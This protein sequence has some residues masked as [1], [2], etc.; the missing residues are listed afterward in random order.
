MSSTLLPAL[1]CS[2]TTIERDTD[3]EAKA[4]VSGSAS[5]NPRPTVVPSHSKRKAAGTSA[6]GQVVWKAVG[7][8][9]EAPLVVAAAK[10]GLNRDAMISQYQ[11]VD[12]IAFTSARKIMVTIHRL[13]PASSKTEPV[14]FGAISF[15]P[16]THFVVC[17]KGAPNYVLKACSNVLVSPG[18][19]SHAAAAET[20]LLS[21]SRVGD[22]NS[23]VDQFSEQALRCLAVAYRPLSEMPVCVCPCDSLNDCV[24]GALRLCCC[25]VC[26]VRVRV[27]YS[28]VTAEGDSMDPDQKL[29]ATVKG[30]TFAGIVASMDPERDGVKE[31]LA[32]ARKASIRTVMIT[33]DYLKTAI[34]I[35]KNIGL[36]PLGADTSIRA[37][38]CEQLRYVISSSSTA[39]VSA[40]HLTCQSTPV[41]FSVAV[42][43]LCRVASSPYG[44]EYLPPI[45]IDELTMTA[46]VFARAKPQDKLEIVKSL[47]RQGLVCAMTGDGVNDAPALKR[48]DIGIAM[49]LSGTSVAKAAS[50]MIL[51]D[52]NF[53]TIVTAVQQGRAIYANIQKF[54]VFLIGTNWAQILI[55]F[56]SVCL[57]LPI[58]LYPLQ[59][60]FI[61]LA[62]DGIPAVALAVEE[63]EED[64]MDFPPRSKHTPIIAGQRSLM[65]LGHFGSLVIVL[66]INYILSLYW[67]TGHFFLHD[68]I[69]PCTVLDSSSELTTQTDSEC[70]ARG[71][72]M[73]RT[74]VFLT[75]A[76]AENLRCHTC[77]YFR[78][79]FLTS[80]SYVYRL[81]R[82]PTCL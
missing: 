62:T 56:V 67:Y 79:S 69:A 43:V 42:D 74:V 73:A 47:Q 40:A 55:I 63:G 36:L 21:P 38:D 32:T 31:A 2:N 35:G 50:E 48:A 16:G 60:L 68:M 11:R 51:V 29:L 26:A 77:R 9:S 8:T 57:G 78:R 22:I 3:K 80:K 20:V 72:S 75:L 37:I 10:F 6:G 49:G 64:L 44:D 13:P 54:V 61:N 12:E 82:V 27:Q 15:P 19:S 24:N 4:S 71:I 41:L 59:V 58:P 5:A 46:V 23:M 70:A 65:I 33:G 17:V 25:C 14:L 53:V 39:I 52:D 28:L 66:V 18:S 45:D 30:L 7:N 76:F 1:L 34:A 81:V